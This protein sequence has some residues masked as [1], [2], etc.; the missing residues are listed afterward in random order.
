MASQVDICNLALG[1]LAQDKAIASLSEQSKEA[2]LFGRVWDIKRDEVLADA[3]WPFA[4][5]FVALAQASDAPLLGWAY[6]Y[7]RPADCLTLVAVTD[8]DGMRLGRRLGDWCDPAGWLRQSHA[9]DYEVTYGEQSSCVCTDIESAYAVYITRIE[10]TGR[11]PPKFVEALACKL[12]E[13]IAPALIGDAGMNKKGDLKQLYMM[14]LSNASAHD[15]NESA[16]SPS[17]TPAILARN[18]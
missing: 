10:D 9:Y 12:A 7:A 18:V 5:T 6:R 14:A 2:R 3:M 13:E 4:L 1:K 11:Y 16:A 17:V 8:E 15:F